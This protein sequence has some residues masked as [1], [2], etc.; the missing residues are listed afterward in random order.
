M[1]ADHNPRKVFQALTWPRPTDGAR[2][3]WGLHALTGIRTALCARFRFH[4]FAV[5]LR[6]GEMK[7][8]P[9]EVV[10]GEIV[11]PI[12][13]AGAASDDLLELNHAVDR[14][15]EDNVAD[16]A[17]IH[18]GRKFLRSS[19]DR[20][21]AFLVVLKVPQVLIPKFAVVRGDPL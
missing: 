10:D 3:G 9:H 15:H 14:A 20:G 4:R 19:Q 8:G 7:V 2:P 18:T 12:V 1:D 6:I 11:L 5:P 16:I 17:G 21:N 13:K